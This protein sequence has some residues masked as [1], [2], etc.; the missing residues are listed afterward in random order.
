VA[1]DHHLVVGGLQRSYVVARPAHARPTVLPVVIVL[2]G[3]DM[4]PAGMQRESVLPPAARAIVVYP[5]GYGRS[6]NA[7]ACCGPAHADQIDDVAFLAAIVPEVLRAEPGASANAV[8]L[9]GYSNGGRMAL[10]MACAEPGMFAGVATIEAVSVFPCTHLAAPVSLLTVASSGD[11]LLVVGHGQPPKTI[12][13]YTQPTVEDLVAQWRQLNGCPAAASRQAA[14]TL[15]ATSWTD[16][17]Q[18]AR[19]TLDLYQ[20]GSH[21][22]PAG[23]GQTPSARRETWA[24][25]HA[26]RPSVVTAS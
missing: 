14:G 2:H 16:C 17:A 21:A 26:L 12:E 25:F 8:F 11:P 15:T 23:D 10:R 6:W 22:I 9:L 1:T 18:H 5:A 7:G 24:F 3:R 19:V 20:G 4:T 13:G